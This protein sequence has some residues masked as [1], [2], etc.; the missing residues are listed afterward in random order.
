MNISFRELISNDF[1]QLYEWC[2]QRFIYE[3]F[4]QRVLSYDEIVKKYTNKLNGGKQNLFIIECDN[5]D[6]GFVQIYI[7]ENDVDIKIDK[8]NHIYE[9]D[10]FIGEEEYISKGIG[11]TIVKKLIV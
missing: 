6:I 9:F 8:Y 10:L 11:T 1:K 2:S 5:K 3:W 4:E 7:F